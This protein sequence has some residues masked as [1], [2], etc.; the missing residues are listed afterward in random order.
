MAAWSQPVFAIKRPVPAK[1][2]PFRSSRGARSQQG[3]DESTQRP[4]SCRVCVSH[5]H[6]MGAAS[7]TLQLIYRVAGRLTLRARTGEENAIDAIW[8]WRWD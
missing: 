1:L 3:D 2:P 4:S 7:G 5:E 6:G 8:T